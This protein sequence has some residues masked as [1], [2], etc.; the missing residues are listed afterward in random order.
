M[1]RRK[2][3]EGAGRYIV[4]KELLIYHLE[5]EI[6]VKYRRAPSMIDI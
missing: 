5:T 6:N 3:D 2:H 4:T 1:D